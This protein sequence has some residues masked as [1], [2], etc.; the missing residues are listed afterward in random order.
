MGLVYEGLGGEG[1]KKGGINIVC[2]CTRIS[3]KRNGW[4]RGLGD[5]WW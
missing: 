1:E 2:G 4:I 3:K 5:W